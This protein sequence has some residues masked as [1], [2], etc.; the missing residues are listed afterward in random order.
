MELLAQVAGA[1]LGD[2]TPP[3][4]VQ[5]YADAI[6][7]S[8]D[9]GKLTSDVRCCFSFSVL[10]HILPFGIRLPPNPPLRAEPRLSQCDYSIYSLQKWPLAPLSWHGWRGGTDL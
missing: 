3:P 5:L 4:R 7:V 1:L 9:R 6:P 2:S 10:I 8:S